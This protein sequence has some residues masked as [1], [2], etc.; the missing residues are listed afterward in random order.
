MLRGA[1]AILSH[2]DLP[3]YLNHIYSDAFDI[4]NLNVNDPNSFNQT[5][6]EFHVQI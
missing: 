4:C 2:N 1:I 3:I 5:E 6:H